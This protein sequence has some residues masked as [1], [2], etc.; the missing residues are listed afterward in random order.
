MGE[1]GQIMIRGTRGVSLFARYMG[2]PVATLAAFDAE[3]W[4]DTGDLAFV[5]EGGFLRFE[6]RVKDMLKV[7]GENVA[8]AEIERILGAVEGVAEVAV[9]GVPDPM[10]DELP[11]GFMRLSVG[12]EA[13][14][15]IAQAMRDCAAGLAGFK[16]PTRLIVVADFPRVNIG[17]ISKPDLRR[18]YASGEWNLPNPPTDH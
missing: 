9:I 16:R 15:A 13:E 17:K 1:T 10:R 2:D 5:L 6:G 8:A 7:S 11:V 4:F 18:R 14:A 12:V 3:G